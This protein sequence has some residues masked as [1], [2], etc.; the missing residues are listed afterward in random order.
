M[1]G[2]TGVAAALVALTIGFGGVA[3]ASEQPAKAVIAKHKKKKRCKKGRVFSRGKCRGVKIPSPT[4]PAPNALVRATFSWDGPALMRLIIE[5]AEGRQAASYNDGNSNEIPDTV[6]TG[7]GGPG[8][9]TDTFTDNLFYGTYGAIPFPNPGNRNSASPPA[10][11][12]VRAPSRRVAPPGST[13]E[14]K[15]LIVYNA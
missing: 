4:P 11:T 13:D 15:L 12:A 1:K 3:T 10:T 9:H 2:V 6:F 5:D 8:P 14:M 7:E